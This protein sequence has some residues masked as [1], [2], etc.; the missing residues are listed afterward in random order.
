MAGSGFHPGEAAISHGARTCWKRAILVAL[1]VVGGFLLAEIGIRVAV[2]DLFHWR[3]PDDRERFGVVDPV[4]G[5]IIRSGV[6]YRHPKG[7]S[8]RTGPHGVRSNGTLPPREA[9]PLTLVVGDSFAFGDEVNDADSWPA[10]LERLT[11]HRVVNAGVPGF[12]LDQSVLRAEQLANVFIPSTIVVSFI[13]HDVVR[14]EMSFWSGHAKPY[15]DTDA[16]GLRYHRAPFV[17]P[18]H[19][20]KAALSRSAVIDRLFSRY[21]HW[22]GPD[23]F[24]HHH[25]TEV[26][27]LLMNRLARFGRQRHVRIVV[28]A[29]PQQATSRPEQSQLAE[30]VL[31]CASRENLSA[32]DLFPAINRLRASQREALFH[33]HMTPRGNR[34]VAVELAEFLEPLRP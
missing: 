26:A 14:C 11:G 28:L 27:C 9:R 6:V 3:S 30:R 20:W 4:V 2:G 23:T 13:P 25:G 24:A 33:G 12:G 10:V 16:N 1:G 31:D 19:W 8:I 5:Q 32:L 22:D 7:F 18:Q 15:F 21:L 29:Q 34:L 17:P